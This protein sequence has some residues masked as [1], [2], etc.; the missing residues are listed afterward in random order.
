VIAPNKITDYLIRVV[1]PNC[2]R[3]RACRPPRSWAASFFALRVWLDPDKLAAYSLTAADVSAALAA[4]NFL[5]AVGATKGQMVQVNLTA[6]TDV[7]SVEQ[8][9]NLVVK[10]QGGA[11]I[12]LSDV[13]NVTLG[14]EDYDSEVGFDGKKA[15]YIGINVAPAANLLD[16]IA[17]V[18]KVW[19]DIH[20][21]LPRGCRARS[22]MTRPSS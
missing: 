20:S 2:R 4:N 18:R 22:S 1:Q 8:F 13:A 16:V 9:K 3:S 10:Q 21:Q 7:R 12:R 6:S 19:P 5:S 15:V 17:G 14:A 11:V